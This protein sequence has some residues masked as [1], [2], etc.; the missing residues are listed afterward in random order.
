[1]NRQR[2]RAGLTDPTVDPSVYDREYYLTACGDYKKWAA[3]G[4]REFGRSYE[5][6]L[7]LAGFKTGESVLDLGTG[8]GEVVRV[9]I[10]QGAAEAV[11][12]DYSD[13]SIELARQ[14]LSSAGMDDVELIQADARRLPFRDGR[15]D[16]VMALDVVEHM[17]ETE[18]DD[19]LNEVRRVLAPGGRIFVHTMPSRLIYDVSYRLLRTLRPDW[20]DDPRV[21]YERAMHVTEHS[22]GTIKRAMRRSG[23]EQVRAWPGRFVYTDFLPSARA[24]H[25]FRR[26]APVPGIR[27]FVVADL[28]S[29]GFRPN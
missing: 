25:L 4:G 29:E 26:L 13:A 17:S 8:R 12:I 28:F 14:T 7:T 6:M 19:A 18:L 3:T 10:E 5:H 15:F 24:Q 21:D 16:L 11:G 27:R 23:F 2:E 22:I 20:P 9:A 1:M